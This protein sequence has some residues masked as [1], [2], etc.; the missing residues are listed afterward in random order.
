[1][2]PEE[3]PDEVPVPKKG[4]EIIPGKDPEPQVWP[5]KQPEIKPGEEPLTKPPAT[6]PEIPS[7]PK[8]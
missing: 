4:P 7:P 3:K 2:Q 6:I 8:E 5:Q 1:M